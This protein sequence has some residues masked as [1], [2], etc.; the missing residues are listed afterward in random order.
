MIINIQSA[1]WVKFQ[2][3]STDVVGGQGCQQL[4]CLALGLYWVF[5]LQTDT[6]TGLFAVFLL[7]FTEVKH[8]QRGLPQMAGDFHGCLE[9]NHSSEPLPKR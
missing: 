4:Y 3:A 6:A 9:V 1:R 7:G 8:T 5:G 2:S